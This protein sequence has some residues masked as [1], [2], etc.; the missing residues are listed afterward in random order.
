MIARLEFLSLSD[1]FYTYFIMHIFSAYVL[2]LKVIFSFFGLYFF[3]GLCRHVVLDVQLQFISTV[4][5]YSF[6]LKC[7]SKATFGMCVCDLFCFWNNRLFSQ[8]KYKHMRS[9]TTYS[10]PLALCFN[11]TRSPD[12]SF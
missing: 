12:L 11:I 5:N 9:P 8:Y 7:N 1:L 10:L 4:N 6:F 3:I 2:L